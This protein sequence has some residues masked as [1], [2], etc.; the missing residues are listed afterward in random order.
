MVP[1]TWGS[2]DKAWRRNRIIELSR[3]FEL[4]KF[5]IKRYMLIQH[6]HFI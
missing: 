3:D 6:L 2:D 1:K 4:R 5:S